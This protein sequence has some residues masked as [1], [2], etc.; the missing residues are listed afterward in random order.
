MADYTAA[1]YLR[2]SVDDARSESMSIESQRILLT[3]YAENLP[4]QNIKIIEY[5]DNGYTGLN[6]E[7]PAVQRLLS[8]VQTNKVNCILV[9]D[10]SRF[11]R[12]SI[13]VEY[14][15]QQVFPLFN[16]RFISVSDA[17]DS[18]EHKGD[19]GGMDISFKYLMNE[20]YS[21][22]I[23][24]KT[25]TA[26]YI[27]MKNGEYSTGKYPYG[28]KFDE[29]KNLIIDEDVAD[30][31]RQIFK[32]YIGGTNKTQIA[33]ILSKNGLPTPAQYKAQNG[34]NSYDISRCKYWKAST[35]NDILSNEIYMGTYI[36]CKR[37]SADVGSK[38]QV[39]R[40]KSEWIKIPNRYPA[41]VT[42]DIFL[43]AQA[44]KRSSSPKPKSLDYL[45]R[46]KVICGCCEHSMDRKTG[47]KGRNPIFRCKYTQY[48]ENAPCYK[49]RISEKDL[50]N[51]IFSVIKK[52][53]EIITNIPDILKAENIQIRSDKLIE[54]QKSITALNQRKLDLYEQ[55]VQGNIT[56]TDF[57][58]KNDCLNAEIKKQKQ[59][60]KVLKQ[61]HE[62]AI[63]D[64]SNNKQLLKIA[65]NVKEETSLTKSLVDALINK[66]KVY[67]DNH[68]EIDWRIKDFNLSFE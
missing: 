31:V 12:T 48:D 17:Y 22:D 1:I 66:V 13:E 2:L 20:Y 64:D 35:I 57:K 40:D 43:K 11:G 29:N 45:L 42:E 39:R 19:T 53:A 65:S 67:P 30:N 47:R 25:K 33:N 3:R 8:D 37:K 38:L 21:R 10:F 63:T 16:V 56:Q 50:E 62:Q 68:I 52:Q 9:K 34:L 55:Y 54:I 18:D 61:L 41:I 46:K 5:V 49:S 14:F 58:K 24:I 4:I 28:Y 60:Y 59:Q 7:R 15:T 23:S 44:L 32:L 27:K 51:L 6:F 26:K 36:M